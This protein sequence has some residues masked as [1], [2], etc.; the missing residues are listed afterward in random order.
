[1][2]DAVLHN[3][4]GI[5]LLQEGFHEQALEEFKMAAHIM[6]TIT[7]QIK[8]A[9]P[10]LIGISE[11]NTACTPS[12][13]PIVTDNLFIRSAPI[14]MSLPDGQNDSVHCTIESAAVLLNMALVY[15][16]SSQRPNCMKDARQCAI[17]L[18]DMAYGLGLR[19]HEDTRSSH[20]ILTA[21]N[22][23]G[24]IY[25]EIGEY[26]KSQLYFDDLSTFVTFLGPSGDG[27]TAERGRQE[28]LLNAMVLRNPNTSA[29]A[30]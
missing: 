13:N 3:N 1:M 30:A 8:D 18:Y 21:L 26:T 2:K 24:Q 25:F 15:H 5:R 17:T 29:A 14:V 20:I 19:I 16:I 6:Y 23:L 27:T 10:Q 9:K 7:Q 11:S 12:R 28:C 22:N 4:E